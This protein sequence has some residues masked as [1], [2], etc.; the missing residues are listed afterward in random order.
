MLWQEFIHLKENKGLST[1]QLRRNYMW[2]V[3]FDEQYNFKPR[4]GPVENALP[5]YI[6]WGE[7]NP[8]VDGYVE[9]QT[10]LGQ[11]SEGPFIFPCNSIQSLQSKLPNEKIGAITITD[12]FMNTTYSNQISWYVGTTTPTWSSYWPGGV[13]PV[14]KEI[15]W[16]QVANSPFD[17]TLVDSNTFELS[18]WQLVIPNYVLTEGNAYDINFYFP[19]LTLTLNGFGVGGNIEQIDNPFWSS[20]IGIHGSASA[21][22]DAGTD[23]FALTLTNVYN[24]ILSISNIVFT[25]TL[26]FNSF[27]FT[28]I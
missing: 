18:N 9:Q 6:F 20:Y 28:Q 12:D 1:E 8:E 23:I 21:S 27:Q 14:T 5:Q 24:N 4:G 19:N 17:R 16:N 25:S 26:T 3:Q 22:Y 10:F 2:Y 11:T 15:T 7:F 13:P